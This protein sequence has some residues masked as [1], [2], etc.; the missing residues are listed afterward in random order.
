MPRPARTE[1]SDQRLPLVATQLYGRGPVLYLG[2][3][4]TW[5]WRYVEEAAYYNRF[6]SNTLEYLASYH[7]THKRVT[8][9]A[10]VQNATLPATPK[11]LSAT[12]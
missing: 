1:D 10:L 3:D 7:V 2:F 4:G 5:R 6:W 8:L 9:S 12:A 11:V